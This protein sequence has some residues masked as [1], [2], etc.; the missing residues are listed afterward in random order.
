ML[1]YTSRS[2]VFNRNGGRYSI[3]LRFNGILSTSY[4]SIGTIS[5]SKNTLVCNFSPRA[6]AYSFSTQ[7]RTSTVLSSSATA[8]PYS[9]TLLAR[10]EQS[11]HDAYR[12]FTEGFNFSSAW[13]PINH[14]SSSSSSSSTAAASSTQ[15]S[16]SPTT[17]TSSFPIVTAGVHL[18]TG[19]MVNSS[20]VSSFIE[21]ISLPD[22]QWRWNDQANKNP[23][24]LRLFS[25]N[26]GSSA[27]ISYPSSSSASSL[28]SS[29]VTINNN[30]D[31]NLTV[32]DTLLEQYRS[33][34]KVSSFLSR[35]N[36]SSSWTNQ[37]ALPLPGPY[38]HVYNN[39]NPSSSSIPGSPV[40]T[41]SPSS[42]SLSTESYTCIQEIV[43]GL[44]NPS[45]FDTCQST[46]ES[47]GCHR[48]PLFP[49]L[50]QQQQSKSVSYPD[51]FVPSPALRLLPGKYSAIILNHASLSAVTDNKEREHYRQSFLDN[52]QAYVAK[53]TSSSSSP[54]SSSSVVSMYGEKKGIS[55]SRQIILRIPSLE[56][57][58]LRLNDLSML[59][60]SLP[61]FN[62]PPETMREEI[63]PRLNPD[64]DDP[65]RQ[66][67]MGCP[68]VVA[69][70]VSSTIRM[71]LGFLN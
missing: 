1:P 2:F 65:S 57:L 17:S 32:I 46:L 64:I 71:R 52:L 37:L 3:F 61:C 69:M 25:Y 66:V 40:G 29:S 59:H 43:F 19:R 48:H 27:P 6:P 38:I 8:I 41:S 47:I 4:R 9:I 22:I 23:T 5:T 28:S 56:G 33:R 58:D 16:S 13:E 63:D 49:S 68:S 45:L 24:K 54:S 30:K 42:S 55:G 11:V 10:D 34:Q 50:W 39:N 62:E 67:S 7:P 35:I 53:Q 18:P 21:I 12:T 31:A 70:E 44:S 36:L 51:T 14:S 20:K 15:G 26:I 60:Q